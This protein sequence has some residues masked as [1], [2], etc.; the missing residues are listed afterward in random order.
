VANCGRR[1][2]DVIGVVEDN[3]INGSQNS[4][5]LSVCQF[6]MSAVGRTVNGRPDVVLVCRDCGTKAHPRCMEYSEELAA[7]IVA[8]GAS[9]W[10]CTNCKTCAVCQIAK[11]GVDEESMLFCD[12]C[13]LG[14]H[15]MCHR[16]PVVERPVGKW[17]CFMCE[18]ASGG[19]KTAATRKETRRSGGAYSHPN[20]QHSSVD[21]D[22]RFAPSLPFQLHPVRGLVPRDWEAYPVDPSIPD[23]SGWSAAQ[24]GRF[25]AGQQDVGGGAVSD[26]LADLFVREDIDGKSLLLLQR[27]DVL[28]SLGLKLGPA[29]KLFKSVRALQT[30]RNFPLN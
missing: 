4:G 8:N 5:A 3:I 21:E 20:G 7:R 29:L 25:V 26:D 30:R 14:F 15:P 28:T 16:P 2:S 22:E 10:Q 1:S 27:Q 23:V 12:A 13:D 19:K 6:C 11:P 24:V 18:G 9:N 17:I